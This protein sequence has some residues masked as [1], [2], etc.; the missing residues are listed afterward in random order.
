MAT[1]ENPIVVGGEVELQNIFNKANLGWTGY[2]SC[3]V[4]YTTT[5]DYSVL[6]ALAR[7]GNTGHMVLTNY[8]A[9]YGSATVINQRTDDRIGHCVKQTHDRNHRC[10]KHESQAQ[11]TI[12]IIG[13]KV[14][15]QNVIYIRSS[16]IHRE[17]H[18][19]IQFRPI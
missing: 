1:I 14:H 9:N 12:C 18:K 4:V 13:N 2:G 15:G 3:P 5:K 17:K 19:L 7:N 16:V 11:N 6:I 8:C 10:R